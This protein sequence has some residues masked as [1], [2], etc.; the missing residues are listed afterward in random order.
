YEQLAKIVVVRDEW[1]IANGFIT[2]TLKIRRNSIDAHYG[3]FYAEWLL[4]EYDTVWE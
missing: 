3:P 4:A 1:T 2:P